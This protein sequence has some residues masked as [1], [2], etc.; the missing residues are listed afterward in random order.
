[1]SNLL[2]I[3]I[4]GKPLQVKPGTMV[5]E[6]ADEAG[7]VI[8]RFCYHKKLSIAANC[9]MCLVEVEKAPKAVPAC[10]TPVTEGMKVFTK[11]NKAIEGQKS[12]MEF[13]LI[14]HPLDCPICDQGG[15][16]ELQDLAMGFG[17]DI[18]RFKEN[19]RVVRDKNIGA[20]IATDMT[21]CIHCTRC[22]RFGR[23]IAGVMELGAVS[24]GEHMEIETYMEHAV[25]SELSGNV[26]DLCPVGALTSK[27]YRYSGRPWENSIVHGIAPH[28]CVGSNIEIDV[29]RNHVMRVLP[30]ENESINEVWLSDR[31]RF[32]YTALT[33]S[34]R[35]TQ[36]MIKQ[37]DHWR[38]VDWETALTYAAE[39]MRSV[40]TSHGANQIGALLSATATTEEAYLLQKLIRGLGSNN[41]DHRLQ[42][43]DFSDQA[44]APAFPY[45]G[46]ALTD[47]EGVQAALVIGSYTRKDQPLINHR[48]R[49]ASKRGA[50]IST[51]NCAE[52]DFNMKLAHSLVVHPF[53]MAQQLAGI[54]KALS[55]VSGKPLPSIVQS[56]LSAAKVETSHKQIAENLLQAD[57][58]TILLGSQVMA[59][60][61]L[62][63]IRTL[64]NV[65]ADLSGSR[66]G[67]LPLGGNACGAWLAGAVPH[68]APGAKSLGTMGKDVNQML[69]DGIKG[70]LLWNVEPEF[71]CVNAAA[72]RHA[73][74]EAD[75]VIVM[76]PF[77]T[78][79]MRSYADVILPISPFTET[80]GSYVNVEG[81]W[82]ST[83]GAVKPLGDSRPGWKVL[84]VLG[85]FF[86]LDGFNYLS[87]DDVLHEVESQME[88][89]VT[90]ARSELTTITA[91][92]QRPNLMRI[93]HIPMYAVD[94][95][96][97][98]AQA[99]QETQDAVRGMIAVNPNVA[100]KLGLQGKS[101]VRVQ[102]NGH[103]VDLPLFVEAS[104]P[105]DCAFIPVGVPGS[106]MLGSAYGAVEVMAEK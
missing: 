9:R 64:A 7:I 55:D 39:G 8:P 41:I 5:I 68:R 30:H 70:L 59:Q 96:V 46:Q 52:Y 87:I 67:Y 94:A 54:A 75:F 44:I 53:D 35:V 48:L 23:E 89:I 17:K 42:Q 25:G 74:T 84:R 106:E 40:I 20:L 97:R 50:K 91:N 22:V 98:R 56:Y 1:M 72:A 29:R 51:V 47:L 4:N 76:S 85:N 69:H 86:K 101:S 71:D 90:D 62:S 77:V 104:I 82:Q 83:A 45:L 61:N 78:D 6:A 18:S 13:L 33:G 24:R 10:A 66:L 95:V 2:N 63:A 103:A 58:S 99:L 3:E 43:L 37:G 34:D 73:I 105:D 38:N 26:I 88:G 93:G 81:R 32:S 12:V 28:D 14:N 57:N 15:E 92:T 19:K 27:P 100:R 65:I 49:K 31:D 16:C 60:P 11:S 102:Q 21:R 36:P 79:N 80:A